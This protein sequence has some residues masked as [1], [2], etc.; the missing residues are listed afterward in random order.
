MSKTDPLA[1]NL[2]DWFHKERA[3][4][5]VPGR[6]EKDPYAIWVA[7]IM[8]QQ[9][10]VT[11]VWPYYRSWMKKYPDVQSLAKASQDEVLK[12]WEGLG[13]YSR[14]RSLHKAAGVVVD[15]YG[16]ELPKESIEL[17]K[18]PG[19]GPY[20]AASIASLA[21]NEVISLIDGNVLRVY[22]RL[23]CIEEDISHNQTKDLIRG[24][25]QERI[26]DEAPGTF[27]QAIMDLGRVICTPK[28]PS[29]LDCPLKSHCSAFRAGTMESYPVKQKKKEVPHYNIVIGLIEKEGLYLIQRRPEK[30]LLG[31]L[32][33]FPGGKVDSGESEQEALVREIREETSLQVRVKDRIARVNHAY[34]HFKITM[35]AFT[36]E[37]V[38]GEAQTHAATENTWVKPE[39]FGDYAFPRA[40]LK[41]L[42]KFLPS[43][44]G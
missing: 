21:F 30:G 12:S 13:Y 19:I 28:Q 33:E 39:Q 3:H 44:N 17:I 6:H 35:T 43:G 2:I 20:T 23:E 5:P 22:S 25:L 15:Q 36:C 7:E 38:S 37:W 32:W 11:T 18:L 29:C 42:E 14:A 1:Q 27:N 4:I 24:Q 40:N 8:L 31:G 16:G 9:T 10:Q 34:T 41:V 26:S